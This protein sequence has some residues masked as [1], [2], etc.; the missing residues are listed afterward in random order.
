VPYIVRA[1]G[2]KEASS[3]KEKD[4]PE[5]LELDDVLTLIDKTT[6]NAEEKIILENSIKNIMKGTDIF[7]G[8]V[9]KMDQERRREMFDMYNKLLD[10]LKQKAHL[11][12]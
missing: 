3:R 7:V 4:I 5:E 8:F 12:D 10:G 2:N 9:K 11:L 1:L 6:K